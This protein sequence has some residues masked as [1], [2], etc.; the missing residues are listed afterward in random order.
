MSGKE[1]EGELERGMKECMVGR[2]IEVREEG[3]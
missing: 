1:R 3:K 2:R